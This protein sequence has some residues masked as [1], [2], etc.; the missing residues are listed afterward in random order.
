MILV[1]SLSITWFQVVSYMKAI[2]LLLAVTLL[3]N[4]T[5]WLSEHIKC[6]ENTKSSKLC[7]QYFTVCIF[8][9]VSQ[10]ASWFSSELDS[11]IIKR[12][13]TASRVS[14][15]CTRPVTNGWTNETT[16]PR[17]ERERKSI[18][19]KTLWH[20]RN[21]GLIVI[22]WNKNYK[23]VWMYVKTTIGI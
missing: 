11:T 16:G 10:W 2:T 8:I 13:H 23:T 6:I 12:L 9:F 15:L 19:S 7:F 22:L 17:L 5:R 21:P 18:G 14:L 4:K 1:L 3:D 20:F